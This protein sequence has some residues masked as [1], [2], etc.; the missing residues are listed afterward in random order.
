V[1]A[2]QLSAIHCAVFPKGWNAQSMA[3]TLAVPGTFWLL[4]EGGMII[5]RVAGEQADLITLAV[6]PQFRRRGL[7]R[8]LLRAAMAKAAGMNARQLFLEVEEHNTAARNLYEKLGFSEV[9]RRRGYYGDTDA[10]VMA[11]AL[12]QEPPPLI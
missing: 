2:E 10:L 7:G 5:I 1:I 11:C 12:T 9:S 6:L 8:E 3:E 4:K